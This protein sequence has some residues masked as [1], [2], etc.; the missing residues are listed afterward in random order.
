MSYLVYSN[1][2]I[3]EKGKVDSKKV[4]SKNEFESALKQHK[5]EICQSSFSLNLCGTIRQSQESDLLNK[6]KMSWLMAP[7]GLGN[8]SNIMIQKQ[9]I[10]EFISDNI[11]TKIVTNFRY[12]LTVNGILLDQY[13]FNFN[14]ESIKNYFFENFFQEYRQCPAEYP[15]SEAFTVITPNRLCISN[16]KRIE[17]IVTNWFKNETQSHNSEIKVKIVINGIEEQIDNSS[18]DLFIFFNN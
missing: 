6:I 5:L 18:Y 1:S 14:Y 12:T 13:S 11:E 8:L 4:P 9:G 10:H 2:E 16:L 17:E 7:G 3:F 15:L